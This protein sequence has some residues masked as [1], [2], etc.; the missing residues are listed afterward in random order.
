MIFR[1]AEESVPEPNDR[2]DILGRY[3]RLLGTV[4]HLDNPE[5]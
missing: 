5:A 4:A 1:S 3:D 2:E